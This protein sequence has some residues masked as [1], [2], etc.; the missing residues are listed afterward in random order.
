MRFTLPLITLLTATTFAVPN[1]KPVVKPR[2]DVSVNDMSDAILFAVEAADCN[3]GDCVTVVA[4]A[5][6]IIAGI[7]ARSVSAVTACVQGGA[8]SV[9]VPVSP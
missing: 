2:E 3:V 6:C 7:A 5:V 8:G 1:P 4:S 9:S